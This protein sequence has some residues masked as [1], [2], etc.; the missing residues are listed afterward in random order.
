MNYC[1]FKNCIFYFQFCQFSLKILFVLLSIINLFRIRVS[2]AGVGHVHVT[3]IIYSR[4][5]STL[6]ECENCVRVRIQ[7][8]L[9]VHKTNQSVRIRLNFLFSLCHDPKE[10]VLFFYL[11]QGVRTSA[12]FIELIIMYIR[13]FHIQSSSHS[14]QTQ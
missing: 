10:T 5:G 11:S 4:N 7:A 2:S 3:R 9:L 14:V 6:G 13:D 12:R 1:Y 8:V